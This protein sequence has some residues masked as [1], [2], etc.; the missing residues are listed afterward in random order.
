MEYDKQGT[1]LLYNI[2]ILKTYTEYLQK[3]H[4]NV[5]VD[6]VLNYAGITR[7]QLEDSGCWYSQE[8]SDRFHDAIDKFTNN[9]AIARDAGRYVVSSRAYGII[10]DYIR[11]F[12][13]PATAYNLLP[14]IHTKVSRG[15]FI[16][17]NKFY[18]G[19]LEVVV[20]PVEGVIEK[21]YQ[22]ENRIGQ[23]EAIAAGFTGHY[24]Q[25]EHTECIHKGDK[26]CRYDITWKEPEFLTIRRYRNYIMAF[27]VLAVAFAF[28]FLSH[29]SWGNLILSLI[30]LTCAVTIVSWFLEKNDYRRQLEDQA[31]SAE[32]LIT[33]SNARYND[34]CLVQEVGQ[35]ISKYLD[36]D[37]LLE[38]I[39]HTLNKHLNFDRGI[40]FLANK[41]RTRLVFR[42]GY[43]IT[44]EQDIFLRQ[45]SLH[46]D[47][48][49]SKG[50]FVVAFK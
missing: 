26:S 11:G 24:A 39:M 17:V 27:S 16:K 4:P 8:V 37:T 36:I 32:L 38:T 34:A 7:Y 50:P 18:R 46:L 25:I 1:E 20:T 13:G 2:S 35:V 40:V 9:P 29:E 12:I 5:N 30:T 41:D 31:R 43:G 6:E 10:R 3:Y 23:F 22:C 47:K 19:K 48:P 45:N 28:P 14:M 44:D 21:P 33:E 49:S 15:A 42:A